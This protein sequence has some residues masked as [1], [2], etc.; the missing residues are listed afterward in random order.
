MELRE[1]YYTPELSEFYVGFECET[2]AIDRRPSM[3][4]LD[5]GVYEWRKMTV[6]LD[7][8]GSHDLCMGEIDSLVNGDNEFRVKYLDQEDLESLGFYFVSR[9]KA[10]FGEDVLGFAND[11]LNLILAFYEK[12]HRISICTRDPSKNKL[13]SKYEDPNRIGLLKIK[14]KTE[15]KIVLEK[16]NYEDNL[17]RLVKESDFILR[18]EYLSKEDIKQRY[19]I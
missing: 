11:E 3:T 6:E 16:L 10:K 19:D 4:F 12:S 13:F 18:E 5:L 17:G 1:K 9:G 8:F 14:N 7:S 2:R 15:L